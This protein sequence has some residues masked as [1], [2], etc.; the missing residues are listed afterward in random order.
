MPV[1]GPKQRALLIFL[2][3]H[4]NQVLS[5][6]RIVDALWGDEASGGEV[7]TLRVHVANLRK[8]LEPDRLSGAGPEVLIT[9]PPGYLLRVDGEG[10]DFHRFEN[11]V[12][13][14]RRALHSDP[15]RACELLREALG[16]W[17][18]SALDD[19]S[20]ETFAQAEIHRL[21]EVR[22][23]AMEDLNEARLAKGEHSDLIGELESAVAAHSLR[24]RLWSQLMLALFRS[25]R[26]ADALTA[27]QR[28]S[29]ILGQAGLEPGLELRLLEDRVLVGDPSLLTPNLKIGPHRLPPAERSTLIG[30]RHDLAELRSRFANTRL[31]TL[32]GSGGVGKTRLAQRLAWMEVEEPAEV[33]WVELSELT[34]PQRIP[35][36]IAAAGGLSQGPGFETVEL[37][38]R[39]IKT[40]ELVIVLDSCEHVIDPAAHV[41]D[42][43]LTGAP[44]VR[45]LATS[46]EPLQVDGELVWRVSSLATPDPATPTDELAEYPSVEMFIERTLARGVDLSPESLPEVALICRRLDGIPLALELAAARTSTLTPA[47]ISQRLANRFSLLERSG[48][49]AIARHRTLEAA[50]DWSFQLLDAADQRLLSRLAVFVASF[51]RSAARQVCAFEPLTEQNVE[52]GLER[53]VEKSLVEPTNNP[54]G[55]RFRLTESVRALAWDRLPDEHEALLSRYRNW[56]LRLAVVGSR[57]VLRDEDVWLP[58]LEAAHEDLRAG[59]DELVQQGE[60]DGAVRLAGSLG[61]YLMWRRTN[62]ALK[63]LEKAMAKA[64]ASPEK[65]RPSTR[66]VGLLALGVFLCYHNRLSEGQAH[67]ADAWDLYT[68]LG[69]AEGLLWVHYQQSYFPLSGDVEES[70]RHAREASNLASQLTDPAPKAYATTRLAE[71]LLLRIVQTNSS[72]VEL[73]TVIALCHDALDYCKTMPR[74]IAAAMA[75][76][77]LGHALALR[78]DGIAG[79]GMVDQ[80]VKERTRYGLG[81][82]CALELVSAGQLAFRL[83]HESK[84]RTQVRRGLE[85]LKDLGIMPAVRP[86]LVSAADILWKSAPEI[87]ARIVRSAEQMPPS[88]YQGAVIFDDSST[89]A[90]LRSELRQEVSSAGEPEGLLEPEEAIDLVLAHL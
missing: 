35:E 17:R 13:A 39:L 84:S 90:R 55:R 83:G 65:V 79:L 29:D 9:Q 76:I 51:D 20:Y 2:L 8:T 52:T 45:F 47:E 4:A 25:G 18:G 24:E 7:G 27:Y 53:L 60:I 82:L 44:K 73:E 64:E 42:R 1:N 31:L 50:L 37:L 77:V 14:G 54:S 72:S 69:H 48:R 28:V 38:L 78:G 16:L 3:L 21:E 5:T 36:Q 86:A 23:S 26:Q 15:D 30:R 58:K 62:E 12:T 67:L 34:D 88:N 68:D 11:L 80:G 49:T 33:W 70:I 10:I 22:L 46:R 85:A 66:A 61:G 6:D 57:E 56:A 40:R 63:W 59:F 19:V 89:I 81:I 32:T 74:P 71:T 87:A 75:R 41:V 43:L